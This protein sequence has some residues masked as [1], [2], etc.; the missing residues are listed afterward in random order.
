MENMSRAELGAV[1]YMA[2]SKAGTLVEE[3]KWAKITFTVIPRR[4]IAMQFPACT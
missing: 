2:E 1:D 3:D 4:K